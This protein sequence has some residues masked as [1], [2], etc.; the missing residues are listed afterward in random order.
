LRFVN[1]RLSESELLSLYSAEY[2]EKDYVCGLWEGN[3]ASNRDK[4]FEEAEQVLNLLNSHGISGGDLLDVGCAGGYLLLAARERGFRVS[5]VEIN[6][7]M[8]EFASR[9]GCSVHLGTLESAQFAE[10]SFDLVVLCDVL[11]HVASP[12]RLLTEIHRILKAEGHL[13]IR[14]PIDS[15][16]AGVVFRRLRIW[17]RGQLRVL[18]GPPYHVYEFTPRTLQRYLEMTGFVCRW[19]RTAE[20]FSP[21][22]IVGQKCCVKTACELAI[23][24]ISKFASLFPLAMMGDFIEMLAQKESTRSENAIYIPVVQQQLRR[25]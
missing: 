24:S 9:A 12:K 21:R 16:L 10:K 8:A 18:P 2:F 23:R 6:R 22:E 1:P 7:D 15:T 25:K 4:L 13:Y 3:Y 17:R 20:T 14:G 5:G 11:E 19:I